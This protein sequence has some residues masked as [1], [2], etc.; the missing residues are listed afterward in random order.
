[1]SAETAEASGTEVAVVEDERNLRE[2]YV[3]VLSA[4]GLRVVPLESVAA[5]E[6]YLARRA[7]D[8]LLLD[9]K[10]GDGDGLVLLDKLRREGLRTPVIVVT[11]FGTVER[12]V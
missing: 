5:A 4:R 3:D 11:A 9:V 1:M 7:P 12:A 10:L 8:L 6:A 2:L